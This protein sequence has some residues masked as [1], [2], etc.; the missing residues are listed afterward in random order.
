[1]ICFMKLTANYEALQN[2]MF[3]YGIERKDSQCKYCAEKGLT[4]K[5]CSVSTVD[6]IRL[7]ESCQ[8]SWIEIC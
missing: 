8:E 2:S 4:Q 7:N 3:S 1:M 6:G 5:Q